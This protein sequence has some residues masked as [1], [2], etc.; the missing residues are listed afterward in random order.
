MSSL[1]HLFIA[2]TICLAVNGSVL[3]S[4]V[5]SWGPRCSSTMT[6]G[7][8]PDHEEPDQGASAS[9]D[10]SSVTEATAGN[11]LDEL[12]GLVK[13][14]IHSQ[15]VKQIQMEKDAARQEQRWETM[16]YQFSQIQRQFNMVR[17]EIGPDDTQEE[18]QPHDLNNDDGG[19][20]DDGDPGEMMS[21]R[22]WRGPLVHR[23]PKLLPLTANDDIEHFFDNF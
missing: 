23:E 12:T 4:G 3:T 22:P 6:R 15:A 17:N 11:K 16:Q 1:V 9:A 2:A 13:S 10:P 8:K 5:R 7:R 14:L 19:D 21:F 20:Y 18:D